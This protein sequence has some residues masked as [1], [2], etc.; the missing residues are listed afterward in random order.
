[1][2]PTN[3]TYVANWP[4]TPISGFSSLR[5]TPV[6]LAEIIQLRLL[7]AKFQSVTDWLSAEFSISPRRYQALLVL[8]TND[9]NGGVIIS[10]LGKSLGIQRNTCTEL[11][12]RME[13]DGLISR[14]RQAADRRVIKVSLTPEGRSQ[15][16]KIAAA[17]RQRLA[18][19]EQDVRTLLDTL[20][21]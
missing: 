7:I 1:M 6:T 3:R 5:A 4:H 10:E 16:A 9:Q 11:L 14:E 8:W 13:A 15:V 17:D 18:A 21:Y 12:H 19:M 2:K 20:S